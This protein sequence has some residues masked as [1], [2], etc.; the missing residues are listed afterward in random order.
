MLE[1]QK[2]ILTSQQAIW[3]VEPGEVVFLSSAIEE[4]RRSATGQ[5]VGRG[6]VRAT[7]LGDG[8]M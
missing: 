2:L 3:N 5:G 6:L 4:E 8:T 7:M 1:L